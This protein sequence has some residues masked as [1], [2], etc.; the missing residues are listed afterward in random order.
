MVGQ[1]GARR[2]RAANFVI[3]YFLPR[4]RRYVNRYVEGVSGV[5]L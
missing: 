2:G 5:D 3:G 1:R 4:S